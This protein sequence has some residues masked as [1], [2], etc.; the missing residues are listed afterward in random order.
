MK[1]GPTVVLGLL[2]FLILAGGAYSLR[3]RRNGIRFLPGRGQSDVPRAPVGVR[4]R[5][6]VVNT[7]K[8]RGLGRRASQLLRDQGFDVVQVSSGAPLR[9]TTLVLDRSNHPAWATAVAQIMG[10]AARSEA[11]TDSSRYLD[12]TVLL[13]SA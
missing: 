1:R 11:R 12:V 13:G 6:E 7:T 2:I 4:I 5:V 3:A 10:P 8:V 9:D